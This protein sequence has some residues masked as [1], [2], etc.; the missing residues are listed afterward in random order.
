VDVQSK[1]LLGSR[2]TFTQGRGIN[3]LK[4]T[5]LGHLGKSMKKFKER[6]QCFF[7]KSEHTDVWAPKGNH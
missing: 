2:M 6:S 4:P 3:I 7:K 1:L 5:D